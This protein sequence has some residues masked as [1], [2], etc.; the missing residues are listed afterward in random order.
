MRM[1]DCVQGQP[2]ICWKIITLISSLFKTSEIYIRYVY[3]FNYHL[4]EGVCIM[5]LNTTV[6]GEWGGW[7]RQLKK[8]KKKAPGKL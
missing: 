1:V 5:L 7:K 2:K 8:K 4:Q 6:W 3:Y